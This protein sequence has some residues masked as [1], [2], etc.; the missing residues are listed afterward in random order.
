MKYLLFISFLLIFNSCNQ[1]KQEVSYRKMESQIYDDKIFYISVGSGTNEKEAIAV[2]LESIASRISSDVSSIFSMRKQDTYLKYNKTTEQEIKIEVKKIN[3]SY[4]L[5]SSWT[6]NKKKYV[7]IKIDKKESAMRYA[8]RLNRVLGQIEDEL[9]HLSSLKKYLFLKNYSFNRLYFKL[10]TIRIVD[11]I[12]KDIDNFEQRIKRLETKRYKYRKELSFTV[13]SDTS[14][15]KDIVIEILNNKKFN[16]SSNGAIK[17]AVNLGK[18]RVD[19]I[20]GEYYGE[21]SFTIKIV[22]EQEIITKIIQLSS[23]SSFN[24]AGVRANIIQD[25]KKKFPIF[26]EKEF[27]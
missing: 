26:L 4:S 9:K 25:L 12:Y 27:R 15:I 1:L 2:A 8:N 21:S 3:F 23:K 6:K 19:K 18:I 14:Q 22:K 7:K 5:I 17:L 13:T 16:I 20:Y 11:P 24:Q 10:D